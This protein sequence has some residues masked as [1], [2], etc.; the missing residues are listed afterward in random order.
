MEARRLFLDESSSVPLYAQLCEQVL[1]AIARGDLRPGARLPS[2]RDVA[3]A[4]AVNPMTINRAYGELERDGV[5]ETRRG[6]GTFVA[7][8]GRAEQKKAPR[9]REIA[10]PFVRRAQ[11]LGYDGRA[12]VETVK[13]LVAATS[14]RRST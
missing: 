2:V 8:R 6:L 1:A 14:T 11:A 12:I 7:Q 10:E 5:I 13:K 9:L 3:A 4:L